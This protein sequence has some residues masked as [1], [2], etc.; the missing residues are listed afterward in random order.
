MENEPSGAAFWRT[1]KHTAASPDWKYQ[2]ITTTHMVASN[3]QIETAQ[4]LLEAANT[5]Q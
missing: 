2:E 5:V 1:A 4:L 3:K